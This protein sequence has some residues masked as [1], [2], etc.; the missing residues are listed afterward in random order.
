MSETDPVDQLLH[1]E[2]A[3]SG[4]IVVLDPVGPGLVNLLRHDV[5]RVQPVAD[6]LPVRRELSCAA[7]LNP[8]LLAGTDLVLM[9]LPRA[10]AA[11]EEYAEQLAAWGSPELRLVAAGRVKHMSRGMNDVLATR[12]AS[13]HAGLGRAKS[14]ALFASSPTPGALTYPRRTYHADLDV[15]LVAHGLVFAGTRVDVGSRLLAGQLPAHG[16]GRAP[17]LRCGGGLLATPL[18]RAGRARRGRPGKPRCPLA[19]QVRKRYFFLMILNGATLSSNGTLVPLSGVLI[20]K[21]ELA[22]VLL[23]AACCGTSMLIVAV[24][25]TT[26]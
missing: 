26:G 4:Q 9:R 3:R 23:I 13:V 10:L 24:P 12:F 16:T 18:G 25:L 5:A 21:T 1:A 8:D 14:R 19:S 7:T 11:L 17:G 22:C 15:T 6:A 20:V 2:A